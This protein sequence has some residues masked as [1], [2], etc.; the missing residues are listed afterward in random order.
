MIK[1]TSPIVTTTHRLPVC[2]T[3][4]L[5]PEACM[6]RREAVSFL[7]M[8]SAA[9]ARPACAGADPALVAASYQRGSHV[10]HAIT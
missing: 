10:L 3:N 8:L 2:C 7:L 6:Q 1:K 4:M 5:R 9:A